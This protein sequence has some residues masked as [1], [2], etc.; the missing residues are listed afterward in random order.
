MDEESIKNLIGKALQENNLNK[1]LND[2][3]II[4]AWNKLVDPKVKQQIDKIF[5]RN[6]KLYVDVSNAALRQDLL[7]QRTKLCNIIN[8]ILKE[9]LLK[10]IVLK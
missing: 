6:G 8:K 4:E 9:D 3:K 7:F 2:A 1:G 10:E 5:V